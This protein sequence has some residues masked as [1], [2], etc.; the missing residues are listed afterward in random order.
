MA[1][2]PRAQRY[3]YLRYEG[4]QYTD[5]DIADFEVRLTR[6]YRREVYRVQVFDFEGLPYLIAERLSTRMLMENKDA[7]GQ[8]IDLDTP[9]ALQFQLGGV[10]RRWMERV[11][12][13]VFRDYIQQRR[14]RLLILWGLSLLILLPGSY[15]EGWRWLGQSYLSVA[16]PARQVE[17]ACELQRGSMTPGGG[18]E[19]ER[20]QGVAPPP[21]TQWFTTWMVTSLTRFMDRVGVPYMR[22][23]ESPIEYQRR[24]RIKPG[25][26]FS[27]IVREYHNGTKYTIQIKSRI[28]KS[29]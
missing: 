17:V 24:T 13:G 18:D 1:L 2:P 15:A 22:Y 19:D 12:L 29:E 8:I 5:T 7:Q 16:R 10:R 11:Y 28:E 4:L 27:T 3:Q 21:R 14:C 9:G 23:L 25:S 6:I 20:Y 26:K